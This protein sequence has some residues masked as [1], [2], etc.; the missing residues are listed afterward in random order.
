[1]KFRQLFITTICA[2]ALTSCDSFLEVEEV[3]KSSIPVF[4]T[5]MNGVRAAIPGAYSSVY[6]Y[7]DFGY[8]L[9]PDVTG[10]MLRLNIVGEDTKMVSEYNYNA[11]PEDEITPVGRI[12][13]DAYEA[14]ANVNNI[15]EYYPSLLEKFPQNV[16]ELA[17]IRAEA[18]FLRA[19]IHFDLVKVYAQPYNFTPDASHP[20]IPVLLKTPGPNTI[21]GRNTVAETYAQIITDLKESATLFDT[22]NGTG[23]GSNY[24]ASKLAVHSLLSRVSLYMENWS[25]AASYA[26]L[27]IN[28]IALSKGQDYLNMFNTIATSDETIFRLS[29]KLKK[30]TI[31]TFYN[32][33]NPT[34][35]A[36]VKLVNL[37]NENPEDLRL[38]LIQQAP[39]DQTAPTLKYYK[40][41]ISEGELQHDILIFRVSELYLIR[42][43]ANVNM[44]KTDLAKTDLKAI[45]ARAQQKEVSEIQILE[46]EVSALREM[47]WDEKAKEFCFEGHR[48]FDL[49]R[50]KQDMVRDNAST[51]SIKE[52]QYPNYRFVLP[53]P[54]TELN[55]NKN[56]IQNTGY[57][58]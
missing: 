16:N 11:T 47:I 17:G 45:Q 28:E 35:F 57:Q 14:L 6:S 12:W 13:R 39:G 34:G 44:D 18:L 5:D 36:D 42:A 38:Q 19:L 48:L 54:Q 4:F 52:V 9:Y 2:F 23:N 58:E 8:V 40:P 32:L 10:D 3:G 43:E 49:T 25:D 26:T 51:S 55:A 33:S 41:G 53:I 27:V 29:G 37:L 56:I 46:N 1:M 20:G 31:G 50:T 24:Y 7:Y 15:I 30:S 22:G 21:T